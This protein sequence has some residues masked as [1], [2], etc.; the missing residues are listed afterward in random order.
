MRK[1]N[2]QTLGEAIKDYLKALHIDKKI[3]EVRLI[4]SWEEVIGKTI[5]KATTKIYIKNKTLFVYLNSSVIRNELFML[6]EEILKALN[7]KAGE[8][9]IERIVLK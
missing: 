4:N 9:I 1:S 2:T 8:K 6:K 3:N 7:E 5:A